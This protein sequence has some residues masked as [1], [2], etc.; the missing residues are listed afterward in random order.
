MKKAFLFFAAA[1]VIIS[2]NQK[3]KDESAKKEI[4]NSGDTTYVVSRYG[5]GKIKIG[6]TKEELEKLLNQ[7]LLLKH[8]KD[9]E[10]AWLDTAT[11]KYKDI[12]VSLFFEP[13]YS[14]DQKAPKVWELAGLSS[15]SN[16]CKTAAGIGI[17]DD[18]VAIVSNYEDNYINMGPEYEQVNDS[19]WL[20]S[21]T[22]YFINV[23]FND[24]DKQL[25]FKILDK[26]IASIGVS[27]AMGD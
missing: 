14:E 23:S 15:S 26:K 22:K 16:L 19:T 9:T 21:K 17:G 8:A 2:C 13:R 18:K 5:I 12:D 1:L 3:K 20:P 24:D 6:M 27:I 4:K 11:A 25:L 10:E 7:Q